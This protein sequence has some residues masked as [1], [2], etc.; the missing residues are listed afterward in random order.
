MEGSHTPGPWEAVGSLVRTARRPDG[1]GGYLVADCWAQ[2]M[3]AAEAAENAKLIA[4]LPEL[5]ADARRFRYLCAHPNWFFIEE[6]CRGFVA[7][8]EATFYRELSREIDLREPLRPVFGRP[9]GE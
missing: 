5:L 2:G 1:T 9:T 3:G 6:L 8:S 4:R 7:K